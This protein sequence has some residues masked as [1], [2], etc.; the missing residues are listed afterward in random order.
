MCPQVW[1]GPAGIPQYLVKAKSTVDGVRAVR[2][3]GLN[4]ME[5]EFVRGVKM[6]VEA[7][8]EVGDVARSLGIRL[9]VHAP[10]FINL[11]SEEKEKREAS[12]MRIWE[13][14]VRADAMRADVVVVHAAYYGKWGPQKCFELVEEGLGELADRMREASVRGVK[15]GVEVTA[16]K[17]Q[18]GTVEEVF[19]VAKAVPNTVPVIDWGH[20][21]ARMGGTL[22]YAEILDLWVREF[23]NMHMH[24]HFT[25][26]K[27]DKK[28]GEYVDEHEPIDRER[29]PFRPLAEE[30]A[31]RDMSITLICESPLLDADAVKMRELLEGLGVVLR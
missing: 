28:K 2:K 4:A 11:C 30:L 14:L 13:S 31:R 18:F 6:S 3:L 9:S 21:F 22:N 16:R 1:V 17:G 27:Y 23:G 10:Y 20:L 5:V 24:T 25:S 19:R 12:K 15:I 26:V 8:R 7:A 29:P